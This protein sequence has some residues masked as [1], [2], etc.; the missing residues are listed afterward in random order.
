MK[1]VPIRGTRQAKKMVERNTK[2]ADI[3]RNAASRAARAAAQMHVLPTK[4]KDTALD[5]LARALTEQADVILRANAADVA[6]AEAGVRGRKPPAWIE[7][8]W[9]TSERLNEM[10]RSVLAVRGQPDPCGRVLTERVLDDGLLLRKVSCPLGVMAV[11]FEARP[12]AV[13]QIASLAVKA[14]NAVVLK[15]G[16]ECWR[17][18]RVLVGVIR[19]ALADAGLPADAVKNVTGRAA[20]A[21]LLKLDDLIDLVIP[22]GSASLVR[23]V[24]RVSRIPV[25]GHS[26]GVCHVYIDAAADAGMAARIAVDSKTQYPAACNAAETILVHERI[27]PTMVPMLVAALTARGVEVRACAAARAI[28]ERLP[29]AAGAVAL[30]ATDDDWGSEYSDLTV[31]LRVVRSLD[32]ALSHIAAYGSRHTEAIVTGDSAAAER[33]LTSVDAAGVYHNASTRFAD[34]Y[35]YGLGA[36]VGIA[37][38]KLHARGPAGLE[39]LVTYRYELRG[40]GHIV[41]DYAGPGG[42]PFRH[43]RPETYVADEPYSRAPK[44]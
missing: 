3:A 9:L 17:T 28:L 10:A 15:G 34:G 12:D 41:A 7:R 25:L 36:E 6:T 4:Q 20:T 18:T 42:R 2:P 37:T 40:A 16:R 32:A 27:A 30:A 35:R 39:S 38:G 5:G 14:G 43:E 23:M 33:F 21:A 22:R 11:I 24:Q 31:A 19:R 13:T 1:G 44:G 26:A 8:L 29:D